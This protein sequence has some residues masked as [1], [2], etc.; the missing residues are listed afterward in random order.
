M[1]WTHTFGVAAGVIVLRVT[2]HAAAVSII[3]TLHS[4][5]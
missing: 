5:P 3:I 4:S 2:F 1:A